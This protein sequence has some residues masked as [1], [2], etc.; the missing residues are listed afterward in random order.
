VT[1]GALASVAGIAAGL[2]VD[3]ARMRA[4]LDTT[5]GLIMAEAVSMKLAEKIGKAAAHKLVEDASR[6]AVRAQRSL[7][8]VLRADK[9]VTGRISSAEIDR[10]FDPMNYQG[11]AQLFIDRLLA[12]ARRGT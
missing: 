9:A 11:V 10:L 5:H 2:E 3:R 1:S 6:K 12:S 8:D 7:K 4:N